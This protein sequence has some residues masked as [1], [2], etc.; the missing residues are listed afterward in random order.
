MRIPLRGYAPCFFNEYDADNRLIDVYT[1]DEDIL[2]DRDARYL[3]DQHGPID[4]SYKNRQHPS[5]GKN[6]LPHHLSTLFFQWVNLWYAF[7]E[8]IKYKSSILLV[9]LKVAML[10][11][12]AMKSGS[13]G[14]G[15]PSIWLGNAG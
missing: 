12:V 13:F 4:S 1:S 11:I 10:E 2:L 7:I 15:L 3:Y 5:D 9:L 6:N 14:D 8:K